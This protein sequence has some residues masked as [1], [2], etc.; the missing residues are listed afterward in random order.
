MRHSALF[1]VA[2]VALIA[3]SASVH[4]AA[5]R[6]AVTGRADAN[7]RIL[8]H[9]RV[10]N[11]PKTGDVQID[12]I[13]GTVPPGGSTGWHVHL[14]PQTSY[15]LS[16]S[17]ILQHRDGSRIANMQAGQA[18]VEPAGVVMRAINSKSIPAVIVLIQ[19]SAPGTPTVK[20][21]R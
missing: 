19:V 13:R 9:Q 5:T 8:L 7:S 2:T 4:A 6:S 21:G 1:C 3:N 11:F 12:V 10:T 14:Y 20:S 16:G 15:M 18:N 17:L